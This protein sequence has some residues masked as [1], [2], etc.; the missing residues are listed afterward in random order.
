MNAS[1]II[2]SEKISGITIYYKEHGNKYSCYIPSSELTITP[3]SGASGLVTEIYLNT[4]PS[5]SQTQTVY[6]Y[7][8]AKDG[9]GTINE[10]GY[11]T[12]GTIT[13]NIPTATWN[14]VGNGEA[15]YENYKDAIAAALEG[16]VRY[17][18]NDWLDLETVEWYTLH[19]SDGADNYVENGTMTWHLNGKIKDEI[20]LYYVTYDANGGS[21]T[22][23]VDTDGYMAGQAF[24]AKSG[25]GLT[26][27]DAGLSTLMLHSQIMLLPSRLRAKM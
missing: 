19:A 21:G 25:D 13:L 5:T 11:F 14:D 8:Q 16:I 6:V 18:D 23:P 10:H 22:V 26:Y 9:Q 17:S 1:E 2:D 12:I 20:Q 3:L 15:R 27:E 24:A 7:A 4:K